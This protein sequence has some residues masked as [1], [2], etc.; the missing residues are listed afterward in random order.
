MVGGTAL[1]VGISGEATFK[2]NTGNITCTGAS[3]AGE[4]LELA[5]EPLDATVTGLGFSGCKNTAGTCTS[6]TAS[7]PVTAGLAATSGG[8]G[9]VTIAGSETESIVVKMSCKFSGFPLTCTLTAAKAVLEFSGGGPAYMPVSEAS[10]TGTGGLCP[11]SGT[12]TAKYQMESPNPAFLSQKTPHS[13]LCEE[14]AAIPCKNKYPQETAL[15]GSSTTKAKFE[16]EYQ[17]K[18]KTIECDSSFKGKTEKVEGTPLPIS[19]ESLTFANCTVGCTVTAE[20]LPYSVSFETY[21]ESHG[22]VTIRSSGAGHPGIGIDCGWT[23]EFEAEEL[24]RRQFVGGATAM[25]YLW[26]TFSGGA[27][28]GKECSNVLEWGDYKSN[29]TG[30][31][32]TAPTTIWAGRG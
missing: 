32:F 22:F 6:E 18:P 27:S 28:A 29:A 16:F 15:A 10:Y 13:N 17:K 21:N 19:L 9:T 25:L 8:K 11:S 31:N 3:L 20:N 5:G 1:A 14:K 24:R 4:T 26:G 30:Y 7:L 23:C 2:T 12:L